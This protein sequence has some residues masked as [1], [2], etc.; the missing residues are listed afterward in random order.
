[1]DDVDVVLLRATDRIRTDDLLL[2]R[3]LLPPLSYGGRVRA[4]GLE[5]SLVRGKSPVP[6]QSGVTRM[7]GRGGIEPPMS[8]DGWFTASCA[9]WRDR[10]MRD[11]CGDRSLDDASVVVKV[12]VSRL[13]AGRVEAGSE[14]VEPSAIG[15]GSRG[16]TVAQAQVEAR[17]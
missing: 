5:P 10:P 15:F 8:E 9:P 1:M 7:V 14:G 16:T 12:L 6:Y 3:Q 11:R 2:D 4:L 13:V 17:A